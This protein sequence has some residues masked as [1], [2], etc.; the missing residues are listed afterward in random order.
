MTAIDADD[1]LVAERHRQLDNSSGA[2][3]EPNERIAYVVPRRNI[4][5][6]I[7]FAAG[8]AVDEVADYKARGQEPVDCRP[9]VTA[10]TS[11]SAELHPPSLRTARSELQRVQ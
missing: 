3:R 11:G 6:W 5:T 9:L 4:E 2:A 1:R 10:C 7:R 8:Q